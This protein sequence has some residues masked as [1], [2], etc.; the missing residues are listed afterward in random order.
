MRQRFVAEMM[1]ELGDC[2]GGWERARRL[3]SVTI[4]MP[5]VVWMVH[6]HSRRGRG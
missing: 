3:A 2:E 5:Q 1:G 4:G 6:R